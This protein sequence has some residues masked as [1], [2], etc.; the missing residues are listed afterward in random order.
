MEREYQYIP[1]LPAESHHQSGHGKY[2]RTHETNA[3]E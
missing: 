2:E 3:S 1:L